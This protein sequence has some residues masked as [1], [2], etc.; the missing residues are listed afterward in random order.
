M[1]KEN[2]GQ[3]RGTR[4]RESDGKKKE[5]V[6]F[7]ARGEFIHVIP[8][9]VRVLKGGSLNKKEKVLVSEGHKGRV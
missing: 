1:G 8:L 7:I 6:V 3:K 2:S 5:G 4:E 9:T